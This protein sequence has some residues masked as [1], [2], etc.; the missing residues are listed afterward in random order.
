MKLTKGLLIVALI[1]GFI[2]PLKAQEDTTKIM[3]STEYGDIIVA[4]FNETPGHRDNIVKLAK[5]GFYNGL[6]FHRVMKGFMIQGGDPNSRIGRDLGSGGPGYTIPEEITQKFYHK[7]GAFCAARYGDMVNPQRN[8]S[9]SQFYIVD[10]SVFTDS[11]LDAFEQR[12]NMNNKQRFY[13]QFLEREE[14]KAYLERLQRAESAGDTAEVREIQRELQPII[15]SAFEKEKFEFTEEQ[16]EVYKTI[17]GAPHLDMQY[18]VYGEVVEG[19]DVVDKIASVPVNGQYPVN[20]IK[21]TV[22]VLE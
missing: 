10:G 20:D 13:Q 19:M 9:G 2:A 18:T 4:L 1:A 22:T 16:R 14:N 15:E 8:S 6:T 11:L 17:G 5:E 3:I 12:I 21:M 7:R